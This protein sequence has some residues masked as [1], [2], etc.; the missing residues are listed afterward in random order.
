ML[1]PDIGWV[2]EAELNVIPYVVR[3]TDDGFI[4]TWQIAQDEGLPE[5]DQL[6]CPPPE[7]FGLED[8]V[9]EF[10]DE[11]YGCIRE[12]WQLIR[13]HYNK[14][15]T[16]VLDAYTIRL[17]LFSSL[18]MENLKHWIRAVRELL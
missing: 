5:E 7:S 2:D 14:T 1:D 11:I 6:N 13:T 4:S 15:S 8:G 10:D 12:N 18:I 3:A 17:P 16:P 9:D